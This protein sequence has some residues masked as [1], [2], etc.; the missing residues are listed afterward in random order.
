MAMVRNSKYIFS[1]LWKLII[2]FKPYYKVLYLLVGKT[3]IIMTKYS[4]SYQLVSQIH[5]LLYILLI[6]N[7]QKKKKNEILKSEFLQ[8]YIWNKWL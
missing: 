3:L 2:Y 5:K 6:Y 7:M 4:P 1:N 8:Y